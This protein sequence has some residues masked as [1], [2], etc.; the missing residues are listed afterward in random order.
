MVLQPFYNIMEG[1]VKRF[2][3]QNWNFFGDNR[4]CAIH[5]K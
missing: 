4:W 3:W 2:S 5:E 1:L